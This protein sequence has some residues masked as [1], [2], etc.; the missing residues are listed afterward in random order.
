MKV[1]NN[2]EEIATDEESPR[3]AKVI[4]GSSQSINFKTSHLSKYY[5]EISRYDPFSY[6]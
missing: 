5:E 3:K 1:Y 4:A 6:E 2:L